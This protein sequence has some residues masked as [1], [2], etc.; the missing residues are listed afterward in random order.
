MNRSL[1]P[2]RRIALAAGSAGLAGG[3]ALGVVGIASAS[4]GSPS[5]PKAASSQEH[6]DGK[7]GGRH[8]DDHVRRH[9]PGSL[10]TA[11]TATQLTLDTPGGTKTVALTPATTYHRGR[12]K[13]AFTDLKSG[14]IV[15]V[16]LLNRKAAVPVAKSVDIQPAGLAGYVTAINGS[17]MTVVDPAGF[18]RTVKTAA[19]T[20]Y[21][22]NGAAGTASEVVVGSFIRAQGSVDP[23]G[24]TLDATR[25][26]MGHPAK[27]PADTRSSAAPTATTSG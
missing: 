16:R 26:E 11:V 20:T 2:G 23:D 5:A 6:H 7:R 21:R 9:G 24:S 15:R 10:V 13:A 19:S 17:S 1:S 4:S 22:K 25:I 27:K 8:G 14:E 3:L 18:T 12:S